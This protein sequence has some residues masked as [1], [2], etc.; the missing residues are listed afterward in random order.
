MH[1]ALA[2][3]RDLVGLVRAAPPLTRAEEARIL[4][5][6]ADVKLRRAGR[7]RAK[8]VTARSVGRAERLAAKV[9]RL[10]Q[11]AQDLLLRA[12]TYDAAPPQ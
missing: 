7:L 8:A 1:P 2:F 12:A 6:Q 10:E 9:Q 11:E 4:R 3:I 5:A